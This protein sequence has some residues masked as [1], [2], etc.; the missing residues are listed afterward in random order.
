V[1]GSY[2]WVEQYR[3]AAP[4]PSDK[5][6]IKPGDFVDV[7]VFN[8]EQM[9]GKGRVRSDG[10]ITL[11]G[12][13]EVQAAGYTPA[14]LA[15]QLQTRLKTFI[16]APLVTVAVE[17]AK[18]APISVIGHVA[19]AGQYPLENATTVLQALALAGGLTE[20][21]KKDRIFVLRAGPPQERIRFRYQSLLLAG[22]R[23][24][25]FRLMGGDVVSVE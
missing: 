25:S 24:A 21:A 12:L 19:R 2:V 9:S 6:L 1:T 13:N 20:F 11:P 23:A 4:T 7:H 17:E 18:P 14:A 15:E 8:M 16:N 5:L 3:V 10:K 22:S